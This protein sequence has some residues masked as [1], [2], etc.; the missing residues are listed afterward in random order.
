MQIANCQNM[1]N[2]SATN[3]IH[4]IIIKR[5]QN[6]LKIYR[7][8]IPKEFQ[9]TTIKYLLRPEQFKCW[10]IS[11]NTK[12]Q[13]YTDEYKDKNSKEEKKLNIKNRPQHI[14]LTSRIPWINLMATYK[15]PQ[16]HPLYGRQY[17]IYHLIW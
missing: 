4:N 9:P 3:A 16:P 13:W 10:Y 14:A 2:L 15:W 12:G 6:V 11:N 7:I 17:S 5:S 8:L 1:I